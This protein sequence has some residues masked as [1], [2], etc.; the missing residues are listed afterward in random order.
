[1]PIRWAPRFPRKMSRS[2]KSNEEC[3][4]KSKGAAYM[5]R[6]KLEN[7]LK[8]ELEN[9]GLITENERQVRINRLLL[10]ILVI[11]FISIAI[12]LFVWSRVRLVNKKLKKNQEEL[13]E[14]NEKL[15]KSNAETEEALEFKSQF[16]A[17]MSHEIRTPMNGIIGFANLLNDAEDQEEH[18]EFV[19]IIIEN[20]QHLLELINEIIDISKI[21]A[22]MLEL[23]K[24]EFS[25]NKL[26]DELHN[27]FKS[28]RS[29]I[30]KILM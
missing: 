30:A 26:M 13:E 19:N 10:I 27:F 11:V 8:K 2:K 6:K 9:Q 16:L 14:L 7:I 24:R 18:D 22:G 25:L 29:V 23:N 15:K 3:Q 12:I 5:Y 4:D 21:E 20:G 1:M 28:D 17:N